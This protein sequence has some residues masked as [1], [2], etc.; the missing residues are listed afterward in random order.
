MAT[1]A[2]E[3]QL[4]NMSFNSS[5]EP[6]GVDM[7]TNQPVYD[8][9]FGM[10]NQWFDSHRSSHGTEP[11]T[12]VICAGLAVL[13]RMRNAYPLKR[14]DYVTPGN[15]VRTSGTF[16]QSILLRYGE[17]R[18]FT[19][20]GGR[21]TRATVPAADRLVAGLNHVESLAA[22]SDKLRGQVIDDLQGW[23]VERVRDYLDRQ[24][25]ELEVNL[26]KPSPQ[27]VADILA[28]AEYKAGAV[29]Q[30]LVGAKLSVRF[31]DLEIDNFSYTTADQQLGR[32]GDFVVGD[33]AFH[34]TVSPM[35]PVL[36]KCEENLRNGYRS[37]LLVPDSRLQ[38]AR[39]MADAINVQD[40]VG[41]VA[42]E[43]FVGHNIEELGEFGQ[44]NLADSFRRLLAKYNERVAIV[45]ADRS[46]LINTPTNL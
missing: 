28:A 45:E 12:Y 23:L 36:R 27:I 40:R 9:V 15:Q 22:L 44:R 4:S 37:L 30:H 11:N 33:T 7:T 34:V 24:A 38:A 14:T 10:L 3:M 42:I 31:P 5:S 18:Q 21:T 17:E 32:P 29:A 39:Q 43:S 2:Q 26:S 1:C 41:V 25:I 20:E 46:L 35:P 16:I 8:E 19:R 6:I 13:E